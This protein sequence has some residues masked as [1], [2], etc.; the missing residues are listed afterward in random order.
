V[1]LVTHDLHEAL[2]MASRVGVLDGGR[3]VAIGSG[4]E[5]RGSTQPAVKQLFD[6]L[7]PA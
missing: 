3:L 4:D 5:V 1:L 6:T 7:A 2:V